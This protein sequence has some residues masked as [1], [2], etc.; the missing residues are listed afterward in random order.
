M[1]PYIWLLDF[2]I[3]LPDVVVNLY[4]PATDYATN[5]LNISNEGRLMMMWPQFYLNKHKYLEQIHIE[6]KDQLHQWCVECNAVSTPTAYQ[7][8]F[9]IKQ[10]IRFYF[11]QSSCRHCLRVRSV[12]VNQC[13]FYALSLIFQVYTLETLHRKHQIKAF[14]QKVRKYR[15]KIK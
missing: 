15:E 6:C 8:H 10:T 12:N 9:C 2:G 5:G 13:I 4:T 3:S 11:N 7:P 14:L 1:Y